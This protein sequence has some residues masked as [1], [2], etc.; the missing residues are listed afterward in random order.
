MSHQLRI[1]QP[2]KIETGGVFMRFMYIHTHP[3]EKCMIGKSKEM[4]NW[5]S[6]V[7]EG[8]KKSGVKV[9]AVSIAQHEHTIFLTIEADDNRAL[10]VALYPFTLVGTGRLI[11]VDTMEYLLS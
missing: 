2:V 8:F 11:P 9:I 4:M 3:L 1:F 5:S 6:E 7:R 10:E